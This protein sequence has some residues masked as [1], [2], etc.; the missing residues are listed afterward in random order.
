MSGVFLPQA[1]HVGDAPAYSGYAHP[2][3]LSTGRSPSLD[4]YLRRLS[5]R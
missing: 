2:I 1:S 5:G 3:V 4:Y